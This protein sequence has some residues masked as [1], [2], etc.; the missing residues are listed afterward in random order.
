MSDEMRMVKYET[1]VKDIQ[2]ALRRKDIVMDI[3]QALSTPLTLGLFPT[4]KVVTCSNPALA[5]VYDYDKLN[6][7]GKIIMNQSSISLTE[8]RRDVEDVWTRKYKDISHLNDLQSKIDASNEFVRL[9]RLDNN[10]EE[11]YKF[12]FWA[13]MVLTVDN[14]VFDEHLSMIC[15]FARMLQITDEEMEDILQ[16]IKVQYYEEELGNMLKSQRVNGIFFNRIN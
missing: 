3:V 14:S 8:S 13:L 12:I 10:R 1:L 16:V 2:E 9:C 4:R 15:D 11:A 5:L 6:D 7:F